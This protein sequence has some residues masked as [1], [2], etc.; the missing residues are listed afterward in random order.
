MLTL[1]RLFCFQHIVHDSESCARDVLLQDFASDLRALFAGV[2][3]L[4]LGPLM[5]P[6]ADVQAAAASMAS[7]AGV[8]SLLLRVSL[9]LHMLL[10][11]SYH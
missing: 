1:I 2:E 10:S 4:N 7:D 6:G 9:L 11:S 5:Q 8:N 3:A